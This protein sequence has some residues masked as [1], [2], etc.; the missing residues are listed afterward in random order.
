MA[1][2]PPICLITHMKSSQPGKSFRN[3]S[4]SFT[5]FQ[6]IWSCKRASQCETHLRQKVCQNTRKLKHNAKKYFETV[7]LSYKKIE[8][9]F[10]KMS[11]YVEG[12]L[13][14]VRWPLMQERDSQEGFQ[15]AEEFTGKLQAFM[16]T[17]SLRRNNMNM[18][19]WTLLTREGSWIIT[20]CGSI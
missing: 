8:H 17:T 15:S 11:G 14:W 10:K 4:L 9:K 7:F 19:C 20:V 12:G 1:P 3:S 13:T 2:A 6:F 16:H 18:K 5:T